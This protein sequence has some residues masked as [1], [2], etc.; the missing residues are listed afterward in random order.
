MPA[1]NDYLK[2]GLYNNNNLYLLP[3]AVRITVMLQ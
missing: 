2:P 1:L 3:L